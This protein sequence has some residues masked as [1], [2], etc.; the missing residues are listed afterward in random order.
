LPPE[1]IG[2]KDLKKSNFHILAHFY[3]HW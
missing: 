2:Q 3:Q 1:R